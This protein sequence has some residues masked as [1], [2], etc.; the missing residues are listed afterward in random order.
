MSH[1]GDLSKVVGLLTNKQKDAIMLN[2]AKHLK[3]NHHLLT[4]ELL[5]PKYK[6]YYRMVLSGANC[7]C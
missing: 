5:Q 1:I 2:E 6:R 4:P 7:F 3:S